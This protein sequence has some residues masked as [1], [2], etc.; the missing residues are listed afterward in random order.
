M[1]YRLPSLEELSRLEAEGL[2][3]DIIIVNAKKDKKLLRLKQL[4]LALVNNSNPAA[5]IKKIAGLVRILH[6]TCL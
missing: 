1:F 3:A 4:T 2:R 6:R 5:M